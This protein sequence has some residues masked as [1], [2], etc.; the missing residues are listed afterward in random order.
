ML[1][2]EKTFKS[3]C[4]YSIYYVNHIIPNIA[5]AH[6]CQVGTKKTLYI[7]YLFTAD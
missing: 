3:N 2:K 7:I 4:L 6:F 5:I 1:P